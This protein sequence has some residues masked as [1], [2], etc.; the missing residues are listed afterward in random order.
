[1]KKSVSKNTLNMPHSISSNN[2]FMRYM[3]RFCWFLLIF[4]FDPNICYCWTL[5]KRSGCIVPVNI[6]TPL[7]PVVF[8]RHANTT[9]DFATTLLPPFAGK[10]REDDV[11][12]EMRAIS[13]LRDGSNTNLI[14]VHRHDR[15]G[16]K[17]FVYFILHRAKRL[18]YAWI[19]LSLSYTDIQHSSKFNENNR[20][21]ELLISIFQT[22]DRYQYIHKF[23]T[24]SPK[25]IS[26]WGFRKTSLDKQSPFLVSWQ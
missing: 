16:Q 25:K 8:G 6:P 4:L 13:R 21:W 5:G 26:Y 3:A 9:Y 22:T 1:M 11:L 10:I 7:Q 17:S 19:T 15:F 2:S 18:K 14:N 23:G 12:S 24:H 20:K